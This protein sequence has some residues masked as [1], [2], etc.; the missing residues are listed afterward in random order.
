MW[1]ISPDLSLK[2]KWGE[3]DG[4]GLCGQVHQWWKTPR[5]WEK[6]SNLLLRKEGY[7]MCA[8]I[9][10][11]HVPLEEE[12]MGETQQTDTDKASGGGEQETQP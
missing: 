9:R 1:I 10:A 6:S 11:A 4:V 8:L 2:T 7:K 12:E 3:G 5:G